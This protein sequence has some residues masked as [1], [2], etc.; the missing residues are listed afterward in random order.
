MKPKR[1]AVIA[2][3]ALL[4]VPAASCGSHEAGKKAESTEAGLVSPQMESYASP[5]GVQIDVQ[6]Q[7]AAE[8]GIYPALENYL[9]DS[10]L[11]YID[12]RGGFVIVPGF[13]AARRFQP[14]RRAVVGSGEKFGIIDISGKYIVEPIYD[15]I[16]DYSEKLAIARDG[17]GFVVLDENGGV[18]SKKYYYISDYKNNRAV[19]SIKNQDGT[20][21]YG[22]MDET[23]KPVVEPIYKSASVYEADRAVVKR[24][25]GIFAL[26]DKDG[27][28]IR[29]L[30][31]GYVGGFSSGMALFADEGYDKYGYLDMDG[32]VVI[33]PSFEFAENFKDGLAVVD[34][35]GEYPRSGMGLID[36]SGK[37]VIQPLYA[38]ILLLGEGMAALGLP[39]SAEYLFAGNKFAL[40]T[41][42]GKI[43]TDFAFYGIG[44]FSN[45]IACAYDN[46][47]TFFIDTEGNM[48]DTLPSVEGTGAM[49]L[50][51]GL[52]YADI[53]NR[54]F[55]MNEQG[56]IAYRPYSCVVIENGIRV[57][58]EK[59]RP[60]K[61]YIVY[62][63]V[64]S[65]MENP[66]VEEKI[67]SKL[68]DLWT[69]IST[70]DVKPA[71][72]L[73]YS[74]SGGFSIAWNRKD[75]LVLRESG[76]FYFFG[77]AHGN[78][79]LEYVHVDT[80]S[81]AFYSLENLFRKGSDYL[82]ILSG[83]IGE[84]M[85]EKAE[86]GQDDMPFWVD[87]YD[88]IKPDQPFCLSDN[89]LNI[90][91]RPYEIAPYAAGFPAFSIPFEE[92]SDIID[93]EGDFWRSFNSGS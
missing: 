44:P 43:L 87:L 52:V 65:N 77:A 19:Y 51:D 4:L 49:E 27:N 90:Y 1:A 66:N 63:P 73:D 58:E 39:K 71:D 60:N 62:Y 5:D 68:M 84:K 22:Y 86:T 11:G 47:S 69:D 79:V 32:N 13:S 64:L 25:D 76:Y 80:R 26:I 16:N 37:F 38:E 2:L 45:G 78:P 30:E 50:L 61:D 67:N 41:C 55:Y 14:N 83:I 82:G 6:E 7:S 20:G 46:L 24:T 57:N 18:I 70:I 74:Y 59:F 31:Y 54:A 53:D 75:L 9:G 92:I 15:Y 40:A 36:T 12:N 85:N 3:T 56:S 23:G 28:L 33:P 42:E 34:I 29:T 17:D 72:I 89:S 35:S 88:G 10:K 91:F 48:I 8:S 21:L 93:T 81:G